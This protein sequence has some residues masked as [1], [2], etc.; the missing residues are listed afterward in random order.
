MYWSKAVQEAGEGGRVVRGDRLGDHLPGGGVQPGD[1]GDGAAAYVLELPAG[2]AAAP[3]RPPGILAVL[4][5]DPGLLVD[6]N[7]VFLTGLGLINGTVD[8]RCR[9][10]RVTVAPWRVRRRWGSR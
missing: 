10:N 7:K 3:G 5:L 8:W 6:A 1:D 4:D 9:P 2:Q